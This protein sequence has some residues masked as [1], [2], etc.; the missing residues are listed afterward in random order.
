MFEPG[1]KPGELLSTRSGS[2]TEI[3]LQSDVTLVQ[4]VERP[5]STNQLAKDIQVE[6]GQARNID[7]MIQRD[8]PIW[9][10]AAGMMIELIQDQSHQ[11]LRQEVSLGK[12]G[13]F[14]SQVV[15]LDQTFETFDD[16]FDLPANPIQR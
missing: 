4:F 1:S 10:V 2:I 16:Q 9:L 13:V 3:A 8:K 6:L 11:K 7:R 14:G 15:I 12:L 5:G